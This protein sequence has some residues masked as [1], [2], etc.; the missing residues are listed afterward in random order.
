MQPKQQLTSPAV[1]LWEEEKDD[2]NNDVQSQIIQVQDNPFKKS[3]P[4]T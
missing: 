3:S 4:D 1:V 2:F